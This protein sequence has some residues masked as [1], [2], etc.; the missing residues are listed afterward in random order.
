MLFRSARVW[1]A[2]LLDPANE[3]DTQRLDRAFYCA[4][5]RPPT[6]QEKES[7]LKFLSVQEATY[8]Q[9][10]EDASKLLY[11]GIAPVPKDE[12]PKDVAAW[13]QLCRVLLNL[14]E[15]ITCY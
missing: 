4:L 2:H 10:P 11:V 15:T 13:T 14:H 5:A 3:S 1:A 9:N 12:N 8:K 6:A 7:L